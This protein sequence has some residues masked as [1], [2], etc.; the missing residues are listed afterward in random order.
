MKPKYC[1]ARA[2]LR[3]LKVMNYTCKAFCL[4]LY[5]FCKFNALLSKNDNYTNHLYFI[6][7]L[8]Y[9]TN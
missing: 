2:E 7:L 3:K 8:C 5:K 4:P 9:E 1:L 6:A